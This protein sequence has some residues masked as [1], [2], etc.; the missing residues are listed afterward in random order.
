MNAPE[1]DL[2]GSLPAGQVAIEA[3]AGTGKTFTI[4]GLAT[5][6]L[7]ERGVAPA[8]LL[9]VTFTRAATAELRS[10]IRGQLVASAAALTEGSDIAEDD[11]LSTVLAE[12][13]RAVRRAGLLRA[14]ADFDAAAIS[15][16]HSFAA[17]VRATLGLTS[18][19]DPDIALTGD[20]ARLVR[21]ACSD[22]L[23]TA[24]AGGAPLAELPTL[25]ALV[26]ATETYVGGPDLDLE[27]QPGRPGAKDAHL[28]LVDLVLASEARLGDLLRTSGAMG[29]DDVLTQLRGALSDRSAGAVVDALR[30]RFKVVL[31]DE[32]QDTDRVQWEIFSTLFGAGAPDSTLVLVGDPK[33]AIYR[34]RGADIAVYLDAISSSPSSHRFTLGTNWRSDGAAVRAVHTLLDGVTFG[35][36][37]IAYA[38]VAASTRHAD[39]RMLD[40]EGTE[41][42]GVAIRL[43]VDSWVPRSGS[44]PIAPRTGRLVERDLVAYVRNLL[45]TASIPDG[46]DL[47]AMRRLRPS[48]IA[49]LVT[50]G[51]HARSA[52]TALRRQGVPAVIAGAGSVLSSWA[53]DHVR[54]LLAAMERPS[55][56]GRVRA[57]ALSWFTPW[58]AR[59]VAG[60]TDDA[61]AVLQERLAAWS[62]DLADRQVA[63]VL[64][65]IWSETDV[66]ARV[67]GEYDGDRSVTDLDHL[68]ELLHERSPQGRAGVAGLLSVLDR[69]PESEADVDIDGDLVARRIESEAQAVQI[70][71]VWKAKGLQF[72]VVCLPML[73]RMEAR[74]DEVI[75]TDPDTHRRTLDL[76]K[77]SDWPDTRT[78]ARRKAQSRDE[79]AWEQFR[80]LYVA[81]TRAQHHTAVW[82]ADSKGGGKKALARLLFP[83]D[84]TDGRLDVDVL[85][86][87]ECSVPK[88]TGAIGALDGVVTGSGRTVTVTSIPDPT[89]PDSVWRS[90]SDG[91]TPGELTVSR[92][93]ADL[94]RDVHRWSF[95]AMTSSASVHV[96]PYDPSGG[97]RGA[98]DEDGAV[99]SGDAGTD[100]TRDAASEEAAPAMVGPLAQLAAG[101][102]FGTFVH[103]VLER[104]D[105][106]A[107]DLTAEIATAIGD[108]SDRTGYALDDLDRQGSGGRDLLA[109]G[110]RLAI[111]TPLGPLVGGARLADVGRRD[112]LDEL[113]F[114]MRVGE[115]GRRATIRDIGV[116]V[117]RH[118]P[119]GHR[120]E[121]WAAALA[122]GAIDVRLAGYL[123]GAIDLV[124][125]VPSVGGAAGYVVAD[126][127][128][129]QLTPWGRTPGAADYDLDHMT[130]AMVEHHYPLQALLYGV[131]LQRYLRARRRPGT[132]EP[133]VL[134]AA[135]LFVRG[136][137]GAGV[138]TA[139]G[140]P[141]GVF[142]WEF[143]PQLVTGLSD[144]LD[145]QVPS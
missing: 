102:E 118:L 7:A 25:S 28:R 144:L 106:A 122:G 4:A 97:D 113:G 139:G 89:V 68:A 60:A 131:A 95:T 93:T 91:P 20:I 119:A 58:S 56:L 40:D 27:P 45:D 129:N 104:V 130:D 82:W 57:Y 73:W 48:D 103:G 135:Y 84:P 54:L 105:F 17:Q 46:D 24:S 138:A 33:Q 137:T 65:A 125:R 111:E 123:T 92:F 101:T 143:G 66:V 71:T 21:H 52:Q 74:Q 78:A 10:R 49:V 26:Q 61:L 145:G 132:P 44:T 50:S 14:V 39:E 108:Q 32:F 3:S 22:A 9:I 117:A 64:A 15:T 72:P 81:L 140:Q 83:R 128:T 94:D 63:E 29:Y 53:A 90:P 23:A 38:P 96:D 8:E 6:F 35:A 43:A 2:Y 107:P 13:G 69:P 98:A 36:E 124:A 121:A 100:G 79:I 12:G 80:V 67:V 41:L 76:A 112:R 87:G 115:A 37:A 62:A 136:M 5:R 110:L 126:Y 99:P 120:L 133:R 30:N 34:F 127:K 114:E 109:E 86:S 59:D 31:I 116:L 88:G 11:R 85:R 16:I 134:G 141:H 75:Y 142:T 77:G 47:G 55:D 70:M 51:A 18:A 19:I 42:S 1:F